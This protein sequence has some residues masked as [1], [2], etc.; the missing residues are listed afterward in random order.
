MVHNDTEYGRGLA[1]SLD[2]ELRSLGAEVVLSLE[3]AE[4]QARYVDEVAQ[5]QAANADTIFYA[6]YEIEAP[7]LRAELA[8]AG[9]DLPML[10]NDGAFLAA[11]IDESNGTAE[12]MYVQRAFAPVRNA[13]DEQWFEAYQAVEYHQP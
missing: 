1:N 7:Y 13:A 5:I 6:G 8:E 10:A 11:T 2:G 9:I 12:G 3:V 4:G